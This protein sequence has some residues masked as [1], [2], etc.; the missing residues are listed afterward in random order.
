M[1]DL[2]TG[3]VGQ[4]PKPT[5]AKVRLERVIRDNHAVVWR[6]AR[7]WGLAP[8]DA[9]DV[10]QR[11]VM[12]LAERLGDIM[13]GSERAFMCKTALY[14]AS[15]IRHQQRYQAEE[16]V[17]DWESLRSGVPDPEQLLRERRA[18]A[19]LDAILGQLPEPLRAVFVLFELELLTQLEVADALEIPQGTVASRLRRAREM[20]AGSIE[21]MVNNSTRIGAAR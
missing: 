21:R 5:A 10:A 15:K 19:Q 3:R 18:R 6:L 7:R 8:A 9:D 17:E 12:V 13:E 2:I 11:A 16:S 14:L 1:Q 4:A 20:V